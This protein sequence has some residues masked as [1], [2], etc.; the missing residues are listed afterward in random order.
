MVGGVD[1][2]EVMFASKPQVEI[3]TRN[4]PPWVAPIEGAEQVEG[5]WH[6]K[7][8]QLDIPPAHA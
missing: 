3:Y 5:V 6:P 4:R 1:G 7:P 8:G 2:N